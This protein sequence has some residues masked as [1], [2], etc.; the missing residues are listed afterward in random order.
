LYQFKSFEILGKIL[1]NLMLTFAC[2]KKVGLVYNRVG[3]GAGGRQ[4]RIK[5][6]RLRWKPE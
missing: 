1:L 6:M 5:M 4:S 3:T 2:F